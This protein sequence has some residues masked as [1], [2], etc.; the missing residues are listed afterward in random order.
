MLVCMMCSTLSALAQPEQGKL[1]ITP[2]VGLNLSNM[3]NN[4]LTYVNYGGVMP[5]VPNGLFL[6]SVS[7][8]D[9]SYRFGWQAGVEASYQLTKRFALA[10][11]LRYSLQGTKYSPVETKTLLA[12]HIRLSMH[13]IQLPL[14]ARFYVLPG[15]AI[16]AG[17]QPEYCVSNN[18]SCDFY[19]DGVKNNAYDKERSTY[20]G[21]NMSLP[22][23]ISY[24][25]NH[26]V[27]DARYNLGLS[28]LYK[29]T[30]DPEPPVS[31]SRAIEFSIGYRL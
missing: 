9:N 10:A 19:I 29:G 30:W 12:E 7:T 23:G 8:R 2:K 3:T 15:L 13:N 5:D 11:E 6:Y 24:E 14:L 22:L 18:L 1:S 4:P 27:F 28:N 21:F 20:N 31:Y 26:L 17:L 16:E 25:V